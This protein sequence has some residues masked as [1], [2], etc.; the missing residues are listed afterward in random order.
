MPNIKSGWK[1][2]R[3]YAKRR[4]RNRM[5]KAEIKTVQHGLYEAAAAKDLEKGRKLYQR[6]SSIVDKAAKKGILKRNAASRR[7]S[8]AAKRLALARQ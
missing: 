1:R 3:Q 7:K 8:R 4:A 6:Y 2:M 5:E